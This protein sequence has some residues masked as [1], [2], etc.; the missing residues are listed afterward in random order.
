M[1]DHS[2]MGVR[3]AL[4]AGVLVLCVGVLCAPS[5]EGDVLEI[6][7]EMETGVFPDFGLEL[8]QAAKGKA[9][10]KK[11][12]KVAKKPKKAAP[13]KAKKGAKKG[14]GDAFAAKL[15]AQKKKDASQDSKRL[16]AEAQ[17][18]TAAAERDT[19]TQEREGTY[20]DEP[21]PRNLS[22]ATAKQVGKAAEDKVY[23]AAHAVVAKEKALKYAKRKAKEN[24]TKKKEGEEN[25][26][27]AEKWAMQAKAE[28][29]E[30]KEKAADKI[31]MKR[32]I[33]AEHPKKKPTA[34]PE[35]AHKK[36]KYQSIAKKQLAGAVAAMRVKDV[37]NNQKTR[38]AEHQNGPDAA[39]AKKKGKKAVVAKKKVAKPPMP[40]KKAVV[41]SKEIFEMIHSDLK[42]AQDI[43]TK[44]DDEDSKPIR[45][46]GLWW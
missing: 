28:A 36:K 25:K 41:K 15:R 35:R 4:V 37:A 40:K 22:T 6:E 30:R 27:R 42:G 2:R 32:V 9:A 20:K 17:T 21:S 1:G 5:P 3:T 44:E 16:G 14:K 7:T 8:V 11:K 46:M 33:A 18:H 19:I 23:A 24:S 13:K 38:A 31:Y 29:H 34:H 12:A 10:A 43:N 26:A 45:L 39:S